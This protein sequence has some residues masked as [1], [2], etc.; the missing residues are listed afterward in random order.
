[1]NRVCAALVQLLWSYLWAEFVFWVGLKCVFEQ[2]KKKNKKKKTYS[3]NVLL[4][5]GTTCWP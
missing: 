2:V 3:L 4:Y 1:M 5:T